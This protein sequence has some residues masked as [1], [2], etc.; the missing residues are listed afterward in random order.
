[1]DDLTDQDVVKC[2]A[3]SPQLLT[4]FGPV[5]SACSVV[6]LLLKS[7]SATKGPVGTAAAP[8]SATQPSASGTRGVG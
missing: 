4:F 6:E 3:L 2:P 8:L 7:P 1:M 5:K